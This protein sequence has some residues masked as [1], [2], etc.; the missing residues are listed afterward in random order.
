MKNSMNKYQGQYATYDKNGGPVRMEYADDRGT[1]YE[2]Y[3][4][5]EVQRAQRILAD[6]PR[7]GVPNYRIVYCDNLSPDARLPV[8]Y[9]PR[10]EEKW[11]I[12]L[13]DAMYCR[14]KGRCLFGGG[15]HFP[16]NIRAENDYLF[17]HIRC[18][19]NLPPAVMDRFKS[20]RFLSS[21]YHL[22]LYPREKFDHFREDIHRVGHN[23][24]KIGELPNDSLRI[25][26]T[27]LTDAHIEK[28]LGRPFESDKLHACNFQEL[29]S[30]DQKG[31]VDR[32]SVTVS[33]YRL[34]LSQDLIKF[35]VKDARLHN[36]DPS[37]FDAVCLYRI[38]DAGYHSL[39]ENEIHGFKSEPFF[40]PYIEQW[41]KYVMPSKKKRVEQEMKDL[42]K[43]I[44]E[45]NYPDFKPR[46]P[47]QSGQETPKKII[48]VKLPD[49]SN[50]RK[51]KL[52]L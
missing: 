33:E 1:G 10:M 21:P 35:I 43:K 12:E 14:A 8:K 29:L 34:N 38:A 24:F 22:H 42:A 19:E 7:M 6:S 16:Q 5:R 20:Y 37:L 4:D 2:E 13:Y 45:G 47:M 39:L 30:A 32:F 26:W 28:I 9:L 49:R 25:G 44:L 17:F 23:L 46:L 50:V 51:S 3:I 52:H 18:S 48:T 11:A 27:A 31:L 15:I 40:E 36:D 41:D